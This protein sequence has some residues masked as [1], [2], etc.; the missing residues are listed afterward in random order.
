MN[1]TQFHRILPILVCLVAA[2]AIDLT[3]FPPH[4]VFPDEQRF[5]G[6]A[7]RLA[8][9]GEFWVGADRAWEMPGTAL[10][11]APFVSLFGVNGAII[12][13][14]LFQALLLAAQCAM[15]ASIAGAIARD[16]FTALV[17]A[18][19]VA[20]YPFLLYYQGLL[21][22]ETLFNTLLLAGVAALYAWRSRGM[23]INAMF[24]IGCACFAAAAYVKATLTVLPPALFVVTALS[25]GMTWR[26]STAVLLAATGL[27]AGLLSLWW[28]RNAV[29]LD[30]F[31]PFT[32]NSTLNLYLGNNPH[33]RNAGLNW[34]SDVEPEVVARIAALPDE[35]A[36]QRAFGEAATGYIKA[37]PAVFLQNV[38]KKFV[39]FWNVVPNAAEFKGGIYAAVSL[40]SFGPVLLLA[41]V[42]TVRSRR[43][44][45]RLV[46]IL[47]IVGYF[48]AVHSVVIASLRYRLPIEPL[49][50]ALAA[51]P[52]ATLLTSA[53]ARI[54][55]KEH[56][57][58]HPS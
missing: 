29:L 8:A 24:V 36:R 1:S 47:L 55:P 28:I 39:R 13:I 34:K 44:W 23:R 17:A 37:H 6:S 16:R 12:P 41:I 4:T 38:W 45:R 14:R 3:Y 27:Y 9:S 10:F 26:R 54:R 18:W 7:A 2:A 32:T 22:S 56:A 49:L 53:A 58:G 19:M 40:A 43:S 20:L 50:I 5:L 30:R 33:N 25:A 11:F 57:A 35:T 51:G 15:V 31:V 42:G 21:L 52:V 46:P 48:T